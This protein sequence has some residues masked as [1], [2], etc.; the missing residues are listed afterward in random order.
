VLVGAP[1]IRSGSPH[2]SVIVLNYRN[3][4]DTLECLS[5]LLNL[6]GYTP[7]IVVCDNASN[8]GS[9]EEITRWGRRALRRLNEQRAALHLP[10]YRFHRAHVDHLPSATNDAEI[11]LIETGGNLGYGGG[12]NVGI[13]YALRDDR[14]THV[15]ILNNDTIVDPASLSQ[16]IARMEEDPKVGLCGATLCYAD[17]PD[18]VQMYGGAGFRPLSGR[19][20]HLG[21]RS[22][23]HLPVD[24]HRIERQLRY[25]S[26]ASVLASRQFLE[27]VGLM[28]EKYFL[29]FEELEW[30]KRARGRFKLAWAPRAIVFHK[31]GASIGSREYEAPSALSEYYLR[32]NRLWFC[33]EHS[34]ISV[35]MVMVRLVK[36]LVLLSLRGDWE[37]ARL[38]VFAT[39]GRPFGSWAQIHSPSPKEAVAAVEGAKAVK[40]GAA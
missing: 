22:N 5:S 40:M 3:V 14:C 11:V 32:R 18:T 6:T 15:W 28:E 31:V 35:P 10:S 24:Q 20:I 33:L 34:L 30:A 37:R 38:I 13:R 19:A 8:N 17:A 36:D 26:G 29:Y 23:R 21:S 39:F 27:Q 4:S 7:R 9:V 25:V 1:V 2:V 12:N 16:L